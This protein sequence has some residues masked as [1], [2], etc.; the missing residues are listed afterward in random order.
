M[1]ITSKKSFLKLYKSFYILITYVIIVQCIYLCNKL[2]STFQ[3]KIR[4][5]SFLS[6]WFTKCMI[7]WCHIKCLCTNPGFLNETF[8][9]VSDNTT[10]YDNNVQMCKKCNL[11]KIKRSHHCSVCDKCIM[12]MDHHCF[13]INSCVGL[14]NQKYFILLNFYTLLLC[15]NIAFILLYKIITCFKMKNRA[16]KE[17]CIITKLDIY[18][19]V[20]N[21]IC[22]LLFGMF[23]MIMLVD[24]YCAIKTNT[25]GIELLKNIKGEVKPFQESLNE[26]FGQP[27]SYLWFL[28]VDK[29]LKKECFNK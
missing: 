17:M 23:S 16:Q 12:K 8:H 7:I 13:W 15:C 1:K 2:I 20:I 27:F 29:K 19:I 5:I 21:M 22:S 24:Q 9:F 18:L 14:Y 25:T 6:F 26:V 3:I 4:I 28:P 11:L 10:E